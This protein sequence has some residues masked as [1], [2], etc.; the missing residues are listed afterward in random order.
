VSIVMPYRNARHTV[1][2]T[3]ASARQQSFVDWELIAVDDRSNDD[4]STIVAA[5]AAGD[6]RVRGITASGAGVSAA[7]N[8]GVAVARGELVA[9]IDADD[10]WMPAKLEMHVGRFAR[11][12][13]LGL[14]FDRV[15][16]VDAQ[17]R[18]TPVTSKARGSHIQAAAL[19]RE[20]PACTASTLVMRRRTF[21]EA[22]GFDTGLAHAEDLELML[23]VACRTGWRIAALPHVL[24]HYRASPAGAS[25]DLPRMLD[26]WERVV[27]SVESYAPALVARHFARAR[28]VQLR[29][30]ARHALR[31]GQ[32]PAVAARLLRQAWCSS[33]AALLREPYRSVGTAFAVIC[34]AA[35][36]TSG[37]GAA[38]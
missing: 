23:R 2:Q 7:R 14:G 30:L 32:S 16:F 9:F 17:G 26:G 8:A 24:T 37:W 19:L 21:D 33:P 4:G 18:P 13:D 22:G 38:R 31:L 5:H 12:G 1:A 11:E 27:R 35:S 15:R 6:S 10:L 28:A 20:N 34:R 29:Y 25:A 36:T 3:L